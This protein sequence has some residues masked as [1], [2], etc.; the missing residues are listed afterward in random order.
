MKLDG[1]GG[2]AVA[3]HVYTRLIT[4]A[5]SP[6]SAVTFHGADL[7]L[8]YGTVHVLQYSSIQHMPTTLSDHSVDR[9]TASWD[10]NWEFAS[11]L[12]GMPDV[13]EPARPHRSFRQ[14]DMEGGRIGAD[15]HRS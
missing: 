3:Q 10:G 7:H 5:F 8:R 6:A 14:G 1:I 2:W 15:I 13:D 9:L 4:P 11:S 12:H